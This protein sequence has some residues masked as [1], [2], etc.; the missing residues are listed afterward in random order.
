MALPNIFWPSSNV[1]ASISGTI[2][3]Q[4]SVA[5]TGGTIAVSTGTLASVANVGTLSNVAGGTIA[6]STG[7][8]ASV[9]NVGTVSNVAGGTV[10]VSSVAT[11]GT[12][13]NVAGG[14]ITVIGTHAVVSGIL[15]VSGTVSGTG[16]I[17]G[18][19]ALAGYGMVSCHVRIS[20]TATVTFEASNDGA[21]WRSVAMGFVGGAGAPTTVASS[22]SIY[23]RPADFKFF[24]VNCTSY[25]NGSI[26]L[27]AVA[28][29]G[30]TSDPGLRTVAISSVNNVVVNSGT[31]TIGGGTIGTLASVGGT[32]TT[33]EIGA[34]AGALTAVTGSTAAHVTVL[35]ANANRRGACIYNNTTLNFFVSMGTTAGT[36]DASYTVKMTP[37]SYYEFPGPKIFTGSVTA[38]AS[39]TGGTI[40]V[41]EFS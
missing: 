29:F 21:D 15:Q 23:Y 28:S 12:V 25:T 24:R 13:A 8:L 9:A 19:L 20:N 33:S 1:A 32:V 38:I 39:G 5:I 36:G 14:T 10:A 34:S 18:S 6:V 27:D 26:G 40:S 31:I 4:G 7:T 16:V 2:P 37:G 41:T 35:A 22:T 30:H 17:G 11:V 3:I